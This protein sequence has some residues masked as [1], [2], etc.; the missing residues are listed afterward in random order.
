VQGAR[1]GVRVSRVAIVLSVLGLSLLAPSTAPAARSEFFGITLFTLDGQDIQG[2]A[3][4]RVRTNR[5]VLK[6]GM[7]QPNQGSFNWDL[8]D[9][10]IGRLASRGIRVVPAMWGNP[11]WVAGSPSTPPIYGPVAEQAWRNFLKALVARYGPGGSYWATGYR[12]QYGAGATPL[13]IRSWQIWNEPNLQKYFTP[14]PSP[15]KYAR[16]V[17]ISHGAIKNRDPQARIVLAGMPGYGNVKAWNFLKSFYS[18]AGIKSKFDAVALHPYG[19]DLGHVRFEI[20]NVRN[21][22]TNGADGATPLWLTELAWGSAPPDSFGL[23]KGLTG[24]QEMLRDSFRMILNN[25]QAWNVQRLFWY[26]WRDPPAPLGGGCS[27]C[28]SAGLLRYNRTAKPA[29]STF[30]GFA[31]ETTPPRASIT[32]GPGQGGVTKDP[33]PRFSFTSSEAGSTFACRV[34]ASLFKPCSSPYTTPLLSNGNHVFFV[35]AIDAPGNVSAAVS[36][37]FTVDTDAPMVT[38]SS[39]PAN[40]S[41]SS[42]RSPSFSFASN[43]VGASFSCQLDGGGFEE[44]SSPFTASGLADAS[45]TF[46]VKATDR[47]GNQGPAASHTWTVDGSPDVSITAGPQNGDLTNNPSPT[48]S[49]ASTDSGASFSCQLDGGGFAACTSPLTTS[50]LS[51]GD[52]RFT[53]EATDTAQNTAAV[54]RAFTVDATAPAVT[55]SSGPADG[56]ATNDPTPTF[57]FSSTEPEST[58]QCRYEAPGFSACAG[59][60]SDTA[61]SPLSDGPHTF[62][63]RAIDAAGN[64]GD[65][66]DIRFVVDTAAPELEIRGPI[67]ARTKRRNAAATFTLKTSE[68][69]GRRC[70]IDWRRFQACSWR[71]RTPKLRRGTHTLEVKATDRAGN[72][73]TKRKRFRIARQLLMGV[74]LP[75]A[76]APLH[77]RCHRV[78]ATLIGSPRGDRLLGTNGPDVIV[79]FGGDDRI[80]GRG[81]RDRICARRGDDQ[82]A[83]G[84]GDDRILGGGGSDSVWGGAGRDTIWGASGFDLCWGAL[85]SRGFR[86]EDR[87]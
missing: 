58:F 39:G 13:P 81:G 83:A 37:A 73:G 32:G 50:T 66:L 40:G 59:A 87:S 29:Y 30:R 56:S 78:A 17:Q 22:M 60:S 14:Y 52:H 82:V 76:S 71:Y 9:R 4:A 23:N 80:I 65:E 36:R 11:E 44:C 54:S 2:M 86:C 69:V 75:A 47:A 21:V 33:T 24:Q 67:G 77:P 63:V 27:F 70:R 18:V 49:F 34:D 84:R 43:E 6:W 15:G 12:Q 62:Y 8:T 3:A 5:F 55:I 68:R 85:A 72:V 51:D 57:R 45:H 64:L 79:G 20:Q 19:S 35:R 31:A 61:T 16:L 74:P 53:V 10:S 26:R 42:E 1:H 7:V 41:T 46:Q 25:R 28:A 48:F 38:M